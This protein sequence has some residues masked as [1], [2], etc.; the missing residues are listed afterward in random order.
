MG[1]YTKPLKNSE[2]NNQ[3]CTIKKKTATHVKYVHQVGS[4]QHIVHMAK[5]FLIMHGPKALQ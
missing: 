3:I 1:F 4:A 2:N 5:P